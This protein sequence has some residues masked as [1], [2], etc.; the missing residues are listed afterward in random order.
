MVAISR[1]QRSSKDKM[2]AC[3]FLGHEYRKDKMGVSH[4]RE[5]CAGNLE[6]CL[7]DDPLGF[8]NCTRRTWLLMQPELPAATVVKRRHKKTPMEQAPLGL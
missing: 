1:P 4:V 6:G 5:F 7:V 8:M 2:M 3:E